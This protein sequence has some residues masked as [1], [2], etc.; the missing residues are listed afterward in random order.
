MQTLVLGA[1]AYELTGSSAFVGLLTFAQLGPLLLLSLALTALVRLAG[2]EARA[3][4]Q[5]RDA[6]LAH[7]VA[8]NALAETRLRTPFPAVGR[9]SGE[10][11]LGAR[12]WRWQRRRRSR[13]LSSCSV[14]QGCRG[15]G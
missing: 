9:S 7:W 11:T 5:L 8:S 12:R 2:L 4:V 6:T 1:Y 13:T 10:A 15:C 14:P 3:S